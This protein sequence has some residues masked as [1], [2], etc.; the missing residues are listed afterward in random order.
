MNS[1]ISSIESSRLLNYYLSSIFAD[2][3]TLYWCSDEN[4]LNIDVN[5]LKEW[6][7]LYEQPTIA[8][9]Q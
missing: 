1:I 4:L 5:H 7:K 6:E 8:S 2:H 3:L 9:N